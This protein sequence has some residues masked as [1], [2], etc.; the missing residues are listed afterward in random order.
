[1]IFYTALYLDI[2]DFDVEALTS[3]KISSFGFRLPGGNPITI[4]FLRNIF[5]KA[6]YFIFWISLKQSEWLDIQ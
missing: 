1:M 2:S 6:G 5:D 4:G 3:N